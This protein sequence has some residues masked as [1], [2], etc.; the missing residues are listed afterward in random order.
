MED[1]SVMDV[2]NVMEKMQQRNREMFKVRVV[3]V[4]APCV[5][6]NAPAT[7]SL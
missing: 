4:T 5:Q 6:C 1:V 7:L 3:G 2:Q